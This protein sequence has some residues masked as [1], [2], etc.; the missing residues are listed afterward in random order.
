MFLLFQFFTEITYL[1]PREDNMQGY[2]TY[3]G[4]LPISHLVF[5]S[6]ASVL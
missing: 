1:L 4:M 6:I 2:I 5:I 3:S